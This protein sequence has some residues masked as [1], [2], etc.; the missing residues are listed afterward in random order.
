MRKTA[1]SPTPRQTV[2]RQ[3]RGAPLTRS[4]SP[5]HWRYAPRNNR[6]PD[7]ILRP[8]SLLIVDWFTERTAMSTEIF[9]NAPLAEMIVEIKWRLEPIRTIPGGALDP[10]YDILKKSLSEQFRKIGFSVIRN[11]IPDEVPRELLGGQVTT[12]FRSADGVWPLY[13]LGP[14]IF[15]INI[16]EQYT[17]WRDFR[18]TIVDGLKSLLASHPA[19]QILDINSLRLIAIDAY[20]SR[21]DYINYRQFS[22]DYLGLKEILPEG[23]LKQ[24]ADSL[25]RVTTKSETTFPL[26]NLVD[27]N[28]TIQIQDGQQNNSKALIVQT[29]VE[30]SSDRQLDS[31]SLIR[32]FDSAHAIHR[33]I[34]RSLLTDKLRSALKPETAND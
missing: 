19:P 10:F 34:F 31:D 22:T 30:S 14:G 9:H 33:S 28:A 5:A 4:L 26:R 25:D 23:F 6:A 18:G 15:T 12:Q 32:W 13:Q 21:H 11:K 29:I 8:T 2:G 7:A 20:S 17:D 1:V 27:S 3:L 24:Y 16:T